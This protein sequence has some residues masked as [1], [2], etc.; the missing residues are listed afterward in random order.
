M[1]E[2]LDPS[3]KTKTLRI[4]DRKQAIRTACSL[5]EKGDIILVAGKGHEKYQDIE[6]VKHPFD[7]V[8]ELK[9][10]FNQMKKTN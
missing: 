7:D 1:E 8:A 6:G 9:E 4:T 2:G 3:Q 10:M 5:A